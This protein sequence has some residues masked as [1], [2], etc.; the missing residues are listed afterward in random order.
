MLS[1]L[2]KTPHLLTNISNMIDKW[3][4]SDVLA[5]KR[6]SFGFQEL[7]SVD[8]ESSIESILLILHKRKILAAA[9]YSEDDPS[10]KKF[11]GFLSIKD[12]LCIKN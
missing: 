9:V 7:V 11:V 1:H 8:Q 4:V 5:F 6:R 12:I 10:F 3:T 2:P